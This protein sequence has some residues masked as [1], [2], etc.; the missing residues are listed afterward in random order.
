M[1]FFHCLFSISNLTKLETP[2]IISWSLTMSYY[3]FDKK[4]TID[5]LKV[6]IPQSA[7]RPSF[8]QEISYK[9]LEDVLDELSQQPNYEYAVEWI[10]QPQFKWLELHGPHDPVCICGICVLQIYASDLNPGEPYR[11]YAKLAID[12]LDWALEWLDETHGTLWEY[13]LGKLARKFRTYAI[14]M[15]E[16]IGDSPGT[17]HVSHRVKEPTNLQELAHQVEMKLVI[18][19]MDLDDELLALA[20]NADKQDEDEDVEMI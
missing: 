12:C 20:H 14:D 6:V 16:Q 3:G 11:V 18:H 5:M 13:S 10:N 7:G 1:L 4:A 8:D 15:L 9:D 17:E 19:E 2:T